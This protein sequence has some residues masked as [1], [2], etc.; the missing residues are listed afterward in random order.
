MRNS[1][2]DDLGFGILLFFF[3]CLSSAVSWEKKIKRF[4]H[5]LNAHQWSDDKKIWLPVVDSCTG[6][7]TIDFAGEE[8][9]GSERVGSC[10]RNWLLNLAWKVSG[11]WIYYNNLLVLYRQRMIDAYCR[12][13][14]CW[15]C[16]G[17]GWT[18]RKFRLKWFTTFILQW[19]D[20]RRWHT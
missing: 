2:Q 6:W 7:V 12:R 18:N 9:T 19:G 1:K 5:S 15:W 14:R 13:C 16:L 4:N 10:D 17:H 11:G 8:Y 20:L 3:Y